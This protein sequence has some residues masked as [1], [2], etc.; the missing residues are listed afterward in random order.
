[1]IIVKRCINNSDRSLVLPLFAIE[2]FESSIK[3]MVNLVFALDRWIANPS[4][5]CF[6]WLFRKLKDTRTRAF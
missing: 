1:M 6:L 3:A 4:F 5:G 2:L